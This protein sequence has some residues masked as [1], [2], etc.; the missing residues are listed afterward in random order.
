MDKITGRLTIVDE[1]MTD[2]AVVAILSTYL[3]CF[4]LGQD[5]A[6]ADVSRDHY[7]FAGE[8]KIGSSIDKLRKALKYKWK[9]LTRSDY[10]LKKEEYNDQYLG[11]CTKT[12][13]VHVLGVMDIRPWVEKT[14]YVASLKKTHRKEDF[15]AYAKEH[16]DFSKH[17]HDIDAQLVALWMKFKDGKTSYS[18]M[19]I[20]LNH[21]K[22][23]LGEHHAQR[24]MQA[25]TNRYARANSVQ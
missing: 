14:E 11:Y 25:L 5:N 2:D 23:H 8:L 10:M 12:R 24:V 20:G 1:S 16:L 17:D 7:H 13:K 4:V 22:Y 21:C 3:Q 18:Q 9:T 6:D 15:V 19:E